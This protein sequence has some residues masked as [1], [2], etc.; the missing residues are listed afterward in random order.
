M[1]MEELEA[2]LR[3]KSQQQQQPPQQQQQR[4]AHADAWRGREHIGR[5]WAAG[6]SCDSLASRRSWPQLEPCRP[7]TCS[8]DPQGSLTLLGLP[9]DPRTLTSSI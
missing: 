1:T 3:R 8:M 7:S 2:Q 4:M 5:P 6:R 9:R